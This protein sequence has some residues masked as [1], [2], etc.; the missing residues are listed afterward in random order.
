MAFCKNCGNPLTGADIFCPSCGA[1][2]DMPPLPARAAKTAVFPLAAILAV[3]AVLA[4]VII[5]AAVFG[6]G[7]SSGGGIPNGTYRCDYG[8]NI[9]GR[10]DKLV[11]SGHRMT[12]H[13]VAGTIISLG[14]DY[15]IENNRLLLRPKKEDEFLLLT[16]SAYDAENGYVVFNYRRGENSIWLDG[17]EFKKQ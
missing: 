8:D 4:M 14:G 6:T 1:K 7:G 9:Y 15:K 17:V 11:F 3:A 5:I 13:N 10:G 2:Q 12:I 16:L